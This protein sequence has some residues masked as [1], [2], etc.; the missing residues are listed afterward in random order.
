MFSPMMSTSWSLWPPIIV[1]STPV[2]FTSATFV[3]GF[4]NR[5]FYFKSTR[6]TC[7]HVYFFPN[8]SSKNLNALAMRIMYHKTDQ[9]SFLYGLTRPALGQCDPMLRL[10]IFL[11]KVSL[12][13]PSFR[14]YRYTESENN[15]KKKLLL[16]HDDDGTN[17]RI[18][19]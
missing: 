9:T 2:F 18:I 15:K 10:K 13:Q 19:Y 8:L 3:C 5:F 16:G 4:W 6:E 11:K 1:N 7:A 17:S 14:A 12:S